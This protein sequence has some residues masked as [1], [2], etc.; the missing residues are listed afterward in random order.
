MRLAGQK[1]LLPR[2]VKVLTLNSKLLRQFCQ[3][4]NSETTKRLRRKKTKKRKIRKRLSSKIQKLKKLSMI[5]VKCEPN[6][7]DLLMNTK[8]VKQKKSTMHTTKRFPRAIGQLLMM[9]S[10]KLLEISKQQKN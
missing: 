7:Q 8:R 10:Q 2:L 3:R 9:N 4:L 1:F 5:F 6:K